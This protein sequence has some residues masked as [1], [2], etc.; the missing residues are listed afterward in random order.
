MSLVHCYRTL[1][2][3]PCTTYSNKQLHKAYLGCAKRTHP[4]VNPHDPDATGA[5]QHVRDCYETLLRRQTMGGAT[6]TEGSAF[7]PPP[8]PNVDDYLDVNDYRDAY[9]RLLYKMGVFW[10][11]SSDVKL[12]KQ[13]WRSFQEHQR[14]R[15]NGSKDLSFVLHIPLTDVYHCA[16]QKL[17]FS[18]KCE[19]I[20][21]E[22]DVALLV[23]TEHQR[24]TFYGQGHREKDGRC[25]D[26][27]V[28]V[29]PVHNG[30]YTV[31]AEGVLHRRYVATTRGRPCII[32]VFGHECFF[33]VPY[34]IEGSPVVVAQM[35]LY[36]TER[37]VRGDL[38]VDCVEADA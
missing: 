4:D 7:N 6:T 9:E 22:E 36:D 30:A 2:L 12:A 35:G 15:F 1:G 20:A 24:T 31:D 21:T 27:H 38:I 19:G 11:T 37:N 10:K 28:S 17:T 34:I 29:V 13:L 23:R 26:V 8:P 3:S 33:V 18:R 16:P 5:F 25:G 32:D 14:Q